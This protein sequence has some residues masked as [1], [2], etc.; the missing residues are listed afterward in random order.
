M[1][2][3]LLKLVHLR[4]DLNTPEE[5]VEGLKLIVLTEQLDSEAVA[6]L[7]LLWS[8]GP[9][10][11]GSF[12][13]KATIDKLHA[14]GL[15]TTFVSASDSY[16]K[17]LTSTGMRVLQIA[18]GLKEL[19]NPAPVPLT[20][21]LRADV[22]LPGIAAATLTSTMPTTGIIDDISWIE[23]SER[24]YHN[25][26]RYQQ[27]QKFCKENPVEIITPNSSSE[28]KQE[29]TPDLS[30]PS[31]LSDYSI[32]LSN[33]P[34][35]TSTNQFVNVE[36]A[37]GRVKQKPTEVEFT[38]L[39]E[40]SA[41]FLAGA[42]P[43]SN[44]TL[45]SFNRNGS[46]S[47]GDKIRHL[48]TQSKLFTA[49]KS[50]PVNEAEYTNQL[51]QLTGNDIE[52][53]CFLNDDAVLTVIADDMSEFSRLIEL[54]AI[55]T[56]EDRPGLFIVAGNADTEVILKILQ[57]AN[58]V[59]TEANAEGK[60]EF[61]CAFDENRNREKILEEIV[62][63]TDIILIDHLLLNAAVSNLEQFR[64]AEPKPLTDLARAILYLTGE[65]LLSLIDIDNCNPRHVSTTSDNL[66]LLHRAGGLR[67]V[68]EHYVESGN[69][70]A[71][72]A[73]LQS[74]GFLTSLDTIYYTTN[75]SDVNNAA[76]KLPFITGSDGEIILKRAT[77]FNDIILTSEDV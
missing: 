41:K 51:L 75:F 47:K 63:D 5:I 23:P 77:V 28:T 3:K 55:T 66:E 38:W 4:L 33:E 19:T 34:R 71:V 64:T 65:D 1:I 52:N 42:L 60:A 54:E 31:S 56:L 67:K 70:T 58:L 48:R 62:D 37:K 30:F 72:L 15:V 14:L 27:I 21:A 26:H 18:E 9:Q 16:Q 35:F 7:E 49:K 29:V 13:S 2:T 32:V 57:S 76:R 24:S 73:T 10:V 43:V 39:S 68:D 46:T 74:A 25:H 61:F 8:K 59:F 53:L 69:L 6:N 44:E 36:Q 20:E 17:A 40:E 12:S 22:F 11:A 50:A 45:N